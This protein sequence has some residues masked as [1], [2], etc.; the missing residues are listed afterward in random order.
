MEIKNYSVLMSVYYKDNP[1]WLIESIESILNQTKKTNDFVLVEDGKLPI[2]LED[3]ITS[4][5]KKYSKIFNVIRLEKNMGLGPALA[6]GIKECKNE[7]VARM[8]SD[9]YSIPTRIEKQL[10][11]IEKNQN[12]DII[13]SSIAEFIDSIENIQS[14]R[15]LPTD[16]NDLLKFSKGRNPFCHPSV[17]FKKTSVLNAGN[18]RTYHLV[19]DYDLWT[20]MIKNGAICHNIKDILVYMR[21]NPEFFKRRGGIKYAKSLIKFKF[22]CYKNGTYSLFQFIK[23]A[24][25]TLIVSLM[26]N[27]VRG[28]I[29]KRI[30]RKR[31]K[32]EKNTLCN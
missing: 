20:R 25:A 18:F 4:Y 13:G 30:L 15:I 10:E 9:D 32:N 29:Y 28:F 14:Y 1:T 16:H 12:T 3:I 22:E 23:T 6:T 26:P 7:W 21:I 11:Y 5:E 19:E 8:D 24:G 17:M 31:V 2:A 27:F